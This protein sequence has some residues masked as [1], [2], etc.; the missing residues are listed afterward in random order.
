MSKFGNTL[1][2]AQPL[3]GGIGQYFEYSSG[4]VLQGLVGAAIDETDDIYVQSGRYTVRHDIDGNVTWEIY[5]NGTYGRGYTGLSD[6]TAGST[7]KFLLT[8]NYSQLSYQSYG[9]SVARN[10][11]DGSFHGGTRYYMY[12]PGY[13]GGIGG[14]YGKMAF[15]DGGTTYVMEPHY[16]NSSYV[17]MEKRTLNTQGTS[18]LGAR[19]DTG[20]SGFKYSTMSG[21]QR[22]WA[23]GTHHV[24]MNFNSSGAGGV[25][26]A[27][28]PATWAAP[29]ATATWSQA[30]ANQPVA[31]CDDGTDIYI[32]ASDGKVI[33]CT[34]DFAT[35]HWEGYYSTNSGS[36]WNDSSG[37]SVQICCDQSGNLYIFLSAGNSLSANYAESWMCKIDPTNGAVTDEVFF[38]HTTGQY[39]YFRPHTCTQ[40]SQ[41]S[42]SNDYFCMPFSGGGLMVFED[43][44]SF[45][46]LKGNAGDLNVTK[47]NNISFTS[48]GTGF[49]SGNI[50]GTAM[51]ASLYTHNA[52]T[53]TTPTLTITDEG[54]F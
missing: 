26:L 13:P 17:G 14:Q 11:S 35:V 4:G 7:G 54:K 39:F 32:L 31:M 25:Q 45:T 8:M 18:S 48:A 51:G 42:F 10:K 28:F 52:Y 49:A 19:F 6:M 53:A 2:S 9:D 27:R 29:T 22:F 44:F 5:D 37:R 3:P 43:N 20:S 38:E 12:R 16:T 40:N 15:I 41:G 34:P 47:T 36:I 46:E 50:D 24:Y 30:N 1:L 33:A 21:I 23:D